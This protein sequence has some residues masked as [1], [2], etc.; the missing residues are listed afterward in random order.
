M[1]R[2]RLFTEQSPDLTPAQQ[3]TFEW[4]V[5]SRGAMIRPYEVLLHSPGMAQAAAELGARVRFESSLSDHDRELVI[6]TAAATHSCAFEWDSHLPLARRAGVRPEA[7]AFLGGDPAQ[8]TEE[9]GLLIGF[10]R[11]LIALST[12][13]E[14]M[15]SAAK[16]RLGEAGL[17]ELCVTIGYYTMLAFVMGACQAC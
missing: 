15:F 7:I 8:L 17:V 5:Q 14:D 1:A 13:P 4:V 2:V 3:Q 16:S 10:V 6:L 9:E 12:V 11:E